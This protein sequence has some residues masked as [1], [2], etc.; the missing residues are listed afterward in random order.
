MSNV[1]RPHIYSLIECIGLNLT[2]KDG[3]LVIIT[4]YYF[5]WHLAIVIQYFGF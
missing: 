2:T 4:S 3:S 1:I 5:I